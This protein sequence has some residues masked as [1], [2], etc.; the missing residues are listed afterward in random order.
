MQEHHSI[1]GGGS[2]K[3][4]VIPIGGANLLTGRDPV[5]RKLFGDRESI[6][7]HAGET[8]QG[9][10]SKMGR[11]MLKAVQR[12]QDRTA[13]QNWDEGY[14]TFAPDMN[15]ENLLVDPGFR[16]WSNG[17]SVA[18]AM[19]QSTGVNFTR[20]AD[21]VTGPYCPNLQGAA[22]GMLFW[23]EVFVDTSY[24]A[25]QD[26][27]PEDPPGQGG[28]L[29]NPMVFSFFVNPG[30]SPG[31]TVIP[32]VKVIGGAVTPLVYGDPLDLSTLAASR[33]YRFEFPFDA[34]TMANATYIEIGFQFSASPLGNDVRTDGWQLERGY[35]ATA[36]RPSTR[37][38]ETVAVNPGD[39][40]AATAWVPLT[41]PGGGTA[42]LIPPPDEEWV[43]LNL[44]FACL[45]P[46]W[47][48]P[49]GTIDVRAVRAPIGLAAVQLLATTITEPASYAT[50][51]ALDR[52]K[53]VVPSDALRIE[54]QR[55]WVGMPG[56]ES[57]GLQ[58]TARILVI[59][60]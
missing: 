31:G 22:A 4:G 8:V 6:G 40:L 10:R 51:G 21:G 18:P 58:V 38:I 55:S 24:L 60:R 45:T 43:L 33:W 53:Y 52:T 29:Y 42:G 39:L 54:A 48:A 59:G 17:T 14:R 30:T 50:V 47:P 35:R 28:V 1:G 5:K 44:A 23:Q 49:V 9:T 13:D 25:G 32:Y 3:P 27:E 11:A 2:K 34:L 56:G 37:Q 57:E 41:H 16:D 19:Y 46:N 26:Y 12:T 20:V 7:K 36:W 15:L